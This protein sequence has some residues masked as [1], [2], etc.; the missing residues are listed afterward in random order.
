LFQQ[1]IGDIKELKTLFAS[2][3]LCL[4]LLSAFVMSCRAAN[5]DVSSK[6]SEAQNALRNAFET[7]WKAE[8]LGANTS[9]LVGKIGSAGELL[10][11]AEM[12]YE[13]G[14]LNSA[15]SKADESLTV[16][17]QVFYA[18]TSLFASVSAKAQRTLLYT[19]AFSVVGA[20]LLIIALILVWLWFSRRYNKKLLKMKIEV[21]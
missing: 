21:T 16:A 10:N 5:D 4:L 15:L 18:A 14:D 9:S 2:L 7:V 3:F 1:K 6:I 12:A 20:V 17:N 11:E 19:I 8:Q 13:T